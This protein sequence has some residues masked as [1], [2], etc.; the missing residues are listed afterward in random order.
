MAGHVEQCILCGLSYVTNDTALD[1][2]DD[3]LRFFKCLDTFSCAERWLVKF[4][5]SHPMQLDSVTLVSNDPKAQPEFEVGYRV[6]D[7]ESRKRRF[8][9]E[10]CEEEDIHARMLH[11][12][13][14][15]NGNEVR[16]SFVP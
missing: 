15:E 1:V 10:V 16:K 9:L 12:H 3:Y 4:L 2:G 6:Q 13:L 8:R 7:R 11:Y 5:A 14:L